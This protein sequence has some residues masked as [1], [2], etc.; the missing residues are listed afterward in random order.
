[1]IRPQLLLPIILILAILPQSASFSLGSCSAFSLDGS[2]CEQCIS[3]YHLYD[4]KCYVDI[5]G[6]KAYNF[7]NICLECQNDY[8][9]VN[10]YCCDRT[11]ISQM[12]RQQDTHLGVSQVI[13]QSQVLQNLLKYINLNYFAPL[14]MQ[15][16]LTGISFQKYQDVTRFFLLY[17]LLS[18]T[19]TY[20][21]LVYDYQNST[22]SFIL[23]DDS[24]L[25]SPVNFQL[26]PFTR[27]TSLLETQNILSQYPTL[28]SKVDA[29]ITLIKISKLNR[30]KQYEIFVHNQNSFKSFYLY[31]G[32]IITLYDIILSPE[33]FK[34]FIFGAYADRA[35]TQFK[36]LSDCK[37][38]IEKNATYI[39]S[40]ITSFEIFNS[41]SSSE[42][43]KVLVYS[44]NST[45]IIKSTFEVFLSSLNVVSNLTLISAVS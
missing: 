11:C 21:R 26:I 29:T 30:V 6:C 31:N 45:S 19:I 5:L 34:V 22:N 16:K 38:S 1:M 44:E 40:T 12:Y 23:V 14:Q 33:Y 42:P 39:N 28:Y 10:N 20:K 32:K 8:I 2:R 35:L 37:A 24:N 3:N 15:A 9:L 41:S 27:I 7:G 43:M 17:E 13:Q 25:V 18:A 36:F 4:G